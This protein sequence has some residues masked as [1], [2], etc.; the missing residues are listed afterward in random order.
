MQRI[1]D[2]N[3]LKNSQYKTSGNLQARMQIHQRFSTNSYG[4]FRWEFEQL[5]IQPGEKIL[6]LGC[7]PAGL[8]KSQ[9]Q[10]LPEGA[11]L[12]LCDLSQGMVADARAATF[13]M[14]ALCSV[15]DAQKIP[16]GSGSFDLVT[17]NHMLYHVPDI[18]QAVS[19]IRRVLRPGGR[20]VAATNGEDHM[21][22]VFDLI[23]SV[24]PGYRPA[25]EGSSRFSLENG[26]AQ[27]VS[28]FPEIQLRIYED[29]L[30][31][32][33]TEPL[34]DYLASMWQFSHW[35]STLQQQLRDQIARQIQLEGGYR[36]QKSTGVF[37]ARPA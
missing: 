3:Y 9:G 15:G 5:N 35:D 28:Y 16:F 23:R 20:L 2:Q 31:V 26:R 22:E 18:Q 32:T 8:W 33:E 29:A 11:Q 17:A 30:F 1:I 27:I 14:P 21:Q 13:G 7:G 34:V 25:A 24:E 4:W 10:R 36:I 37:V 12:V 19:E 6:D